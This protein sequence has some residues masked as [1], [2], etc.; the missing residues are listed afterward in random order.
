VDNLPATLLNLSLTGYAVGAVA[1]LLFLRAEKLANLFT[2]GCGSLASLC[3]VVSSVVSL[4]TGTAAASR[5]LQL[6]P[7][8]A[9]VGKSSTGF[10]PRPA[11]GW[12]VAKSETRRFKTGRR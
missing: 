5:S 10:T 7:S 3:G 6:L 12:R 11:T 2:F 4:A 8:K 1:G 9:G